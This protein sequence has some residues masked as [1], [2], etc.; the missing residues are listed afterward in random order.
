MMISVSLP[1]PV[2]G[3]PPG[4]G[5]E[6]AGADASVQQVT[7]RAMGCTVRA[8]VDS[9]APE[10]TAALERMPV[11]F[12]AWERRLSRFRADSELSRLNDRAG[13][14]TRVSPI[15]WRALRTARQAAAATGGLVVPTLGAAIAAAGYDRSF[16]RLE[17]GA[18][19]AGGPAGAGPP[20]RGPAPASDWRTIE[21]DRRRHAVRVPEG[22]RLDLGGTAKG[23]AADRAARRLAAAGPALVDA[24]GDVAVARPPRWAA[25]WAVGV[26]RPAAGGAAPAAG[27]GTPLVAVLRVAAG[28]VA[29]SGRDFRTWLRD[30]VR[31]H[32]VLDPR[33]GREADTDLLSATAIAPTAAAAEAAAKAVLILGAAAGL[34]WL[35]ARP[36]LAGLACGQAGRVWGS[37]RLAD[38]LWA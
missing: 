32:H 25:G 34:A 3:S 7:F 17:A 18:P 23:W 12:E 35:D 4:T 22:C 29:T 19:G 30:G 13:R 5:P 16:E 31:R 21:W 28:G 9:A 1:A 38:Y 8:L 14:W 20:A 27:A 15:V 37:R 10:A 2:P 26:A 24:G 11:W 36:H 6:T 33:T